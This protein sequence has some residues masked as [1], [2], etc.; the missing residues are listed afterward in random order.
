M[1]SP[2]CN[3]VAGHDI[4]RTTNKKHVCCHFIHLFKRYI[5]HQTIPD[6]VQTEITLTQTYETMHTAT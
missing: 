6:K 5:I 1:G 2:P 3:D 4:I